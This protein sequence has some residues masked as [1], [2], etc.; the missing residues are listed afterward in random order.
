MRTTSVVPALA[1]AAVACSLAACLHESSSEEP[2][3]GRLAYVEETG[4]PGGGLEAQLVTS[5][6]DGS[7][8]QDVPIDADWVNAV[9]LRW[10]P[11]GTRL[12]AIFAGA[13]YSYTVVAERDG[14]SSESFFAGCSEWSPDQSQLGCMEY[15]AGTG[16]VTLAVLNLEV[17][18]LTQL[19]EALGPTFDHSFG[20]NAAS[21]ALYY[22]YYAAAA[23]QSD[24]YEIDVTSKVTT[25][26]ATGIPGKVDSIS[27]D[28]QWVL[29]ARSASSASDGQIVRRH[30]ATGSELP[31]ANLD[32]NGADSGYGAA[33]FLESA[34]AVIVARKVSADAWEHA[35]VTIS[36]S[37]VRAA[38]MEVPNGTWGPQP[39]DFFPQ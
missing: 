20:W 10:S 14:A 3:S 21:T 30:V 15:G 17:G 24:L 25:T 39:Y 38:R 13:D 6:A 7:E 27:R 18:G 1:A 37:G 16:K 22:S 29:I 33:R 23:N 35:Y 9:Q 8:A 31:I 2:I 34:D 28:G 4:T 19:G 12:L 26:I 32:W 36:P 5:N 11:D